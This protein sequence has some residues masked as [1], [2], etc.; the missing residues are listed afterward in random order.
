[1]DLPFLQGWESNL[2]HW[3]VKTIGETVL[4]I[5]DVKL[6]IFIRDIGPVDF[7]SEPIKEETKGVMIV[8]GHLQV[9]I[10]ISR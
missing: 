2:K 7:P 4:A 5:S 9:V 3:G 10:N 1:M 8:S 6:S